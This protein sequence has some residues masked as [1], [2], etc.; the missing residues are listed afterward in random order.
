[1]RWDIRG[2][3]AKSRDNVCAMGGKNMKKEE[4]QSQ[5]SEF[6]TEHVIIVEVGQILLIHW[7]QNFD[8]VLGLYGKAW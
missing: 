2:I 1:M 6:G 4:E 8:Q 3:R 7:F 5:G